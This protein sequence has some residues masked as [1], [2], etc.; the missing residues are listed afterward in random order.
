MFVEGLLKKLIES[1]WLFENTNIKITNYYQPIISSKYIA[2]I[3]H[4]RLAN[5]QIH[6]QRQ[7]L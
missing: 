7:T 3:Y 6:A 4:R 2:K 5:K 1:W